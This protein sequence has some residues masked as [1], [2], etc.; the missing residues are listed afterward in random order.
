MAKHKSLG[1]NAKN[2]SKIIWWH[3]DEKNK[4]YMIKPEE[5]TKYERLIEKYGEMFIPDDEK[6]YFY[7][8]SIIE[9]TN[10]KIKAD[11]VTDTPI[12]MRINEMNKSYFEDFTD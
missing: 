2:F 9:E 3:I 10:V 8:L 1:E 12:Q 11:I 4:F 7:P 5:E 6:L